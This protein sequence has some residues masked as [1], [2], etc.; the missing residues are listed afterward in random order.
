M[1]NRQLIERKATARPGGPDK[2]AYATFPV[3]A[4]G[5]RGGELR[6]GVPKLGEHTREVLVELGFADSDIAAFIQTGAV[7]TA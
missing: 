7:R 1:S 5:R 3:F 6:A 2:A 4:D